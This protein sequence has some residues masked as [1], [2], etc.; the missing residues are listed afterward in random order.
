MTRLT[1]IPAGATVTVHTPENAQVVRVRDMLANAGAELRLMSGILPI[2]PTLSTAAGTTLRFTFGAEGD[3]PATE[4]G[5]ALR[6]QNTSEGD[7]TIWIAFDV[8]PE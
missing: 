1:D 6:I 5:A 2:S 7:T 8:L 3:A 4:P